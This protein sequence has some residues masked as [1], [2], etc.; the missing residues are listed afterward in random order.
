MTEMGPPSANQCMANH[1]ARETGKQRYQQVISIIGSLLS[2]NISHIIHAF[3]KRAPHY[4]RMCVLLHQLAPWGFW[5]T[6][7]ERKI[8]VCNGFCHYSLCCDSTINLVAVEEWL[9]RGIT[10]EWGC[11]PFSLL[12][13][14]TKVYRCHIRFTS[15]TALLHVPGWVNL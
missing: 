3:P 8:E 15:T 13:R 9:D 1:R 7:A 11:H 6:T 10:S 14:Y 12:Q 2:V 4:L 5:I